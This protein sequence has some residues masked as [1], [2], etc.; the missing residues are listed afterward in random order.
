MGLPPAPPPTP[1]SP[2]LTSCSSRT[3]PTLTCDIKHHSMACKSTMSPPRPSFKGQSTPPP[4]FVLSPP[5]N[6]PQPMALWPKHRKWTMQQAPATAPN[7]TVFARNLPSPPHHP[8]TLYGDS[9]QESTSPLSNA[10]G[11]STPGP[12]SQP[13][14]HQS[15]SPTT[16][17]LKN[18][19]R[20]FESLVMPWFRGNN[21]PP[22]QTTIAIT[23]PP[24]TRNRLP[25]LS[26]TTSNNNSN[27]NGGVAFTVRCS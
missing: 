10:P 7:R 25:P 2:D 23:T 18:P 5:S 13:Q 15:T 4:G 19:H 16:S 22:P 21:N 24:E 14:P 9:S 26:H 17:S 11:L 20:A 8:H 27:N 3:S 12:R 1:D 6:I